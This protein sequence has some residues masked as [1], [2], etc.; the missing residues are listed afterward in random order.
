MAQ[1]TRV[2]PVAWVDL[3]WIP[4]GAGAA[5]PIVRWNGVLFETV[6]AKLEGRAVRDLFHAGLEVGIG[7][8]RYVI[9]MAPAWGAGS[10]GAQVVGVGPV[11]TRW[12]GRSRFFRYQVRCWRDGIIPDLA[13]AVDSPRRVI[14][15]ADQARRLLDLAPQFP[16]ATWGRDEMHTGDMWNSNSLVAWLLAGC[17]VDTSVIQPP[18]GGRAPGWNAGLVVAGV[19]PRMR[20][21]R[22]V[23]PRM[24][25][26][27]RRSRFVGRP[28]PRSRTTGAG[29][30]SRGG[31]GGEWSS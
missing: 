8:D 1:G 17:G 29:R 23:R 25:S 30:A 4:L 6:A 19:T 9:E 22:Q 7:E 12:L 16:T 31:G 14:D 15:G 20:E 24:R 2:P 5:V 10:A 18:A 27:W 21:E 28:A 26:T 13:Y 11:G 3:Y